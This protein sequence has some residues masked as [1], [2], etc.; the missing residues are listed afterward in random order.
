MK[1]SIRQAVPEDARAIGAVQVVVWRTTYQ[2]IIEDKV[3][4]N[5][6][7]R[8]RAN[9]WQ[10]QFE[11]APAILIYVAVDQEGEIVGFASGGPERRGN[12]DFSAELYTIYLLQETQRQGVGRRL[13]NTIL[14]ELQKAGHKSV[15]IWA[16][17]ENQALFF[18]EALG[19]EPVSKETV[20]IGDIEHTE[21]AYGWYF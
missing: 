6:S 10:L 17:E 13:V 1:Y 11:Q 4:D 15:I 20:Q 12:N 7:V 14:N 2:G 21:I 5:L 9:F 3:L 8:E 16:L 18:Y 19:F